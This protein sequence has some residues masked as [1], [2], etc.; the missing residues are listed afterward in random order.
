MQFDNG[1]TGAAGL[2]GFIRSINGSFPVL[3]CNLDTSG[4]PALAGLVQ[5]FALLPLQHSNATVGVVGL[6]SVETPETSNPGASVKFL[7]YA[8]TLPACVADARAAGADLIIALTHIGFEDDQA[9]AASS[10]AAGVDLIVGAVVRGGLLGHGWEGSPRLAGLRLVCWP[11]H[12]HE[13]RCGMPKPTRLTFAH[14]STADLCCPFRQPTA[15]Q[16]ATPTPSCTPARRPRCWSARPQMKPP[17]WPAASP[18]GSPTTAPAS[19][20]PSCKRCMAA[21]T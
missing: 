19:A 1:A 14:S 9:L 13:Q 10:A 17:R 7:P 16:A 12:A 11:V 2:E 3:S 15:T 20:S 6:T 4:E 8:D 21:A 18:P 5:R